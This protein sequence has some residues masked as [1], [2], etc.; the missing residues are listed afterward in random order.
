MFEHHLLIQERRQQAPA[1]GATQYSQCH[2][3]FSD[4]EGGA[5]G[6]AGFIDAPVSAPPREC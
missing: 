5:E 1:M 3:K 4:D 6:A 2:E